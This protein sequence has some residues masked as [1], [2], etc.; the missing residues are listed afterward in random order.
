MGEVSWGKLVKQGNSYQEVMLA[1]ELILTVHLCH[2]KDLQAVIYHT[3]VTY[4]QP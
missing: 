3:N 4:P 2:G 1:F